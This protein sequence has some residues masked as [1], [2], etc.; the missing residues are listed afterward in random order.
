MAHGTDSVIDGRLVDS[1]I[2]SLFPRLGG[3]LSPLLV[4]LPSEQLIEEEAILLGELLDP[5]EDV[6]NGGVAHELSEDLRL[7]LPQGLLPPEAFDEAGKR[8][9]IV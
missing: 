7:L 4:F 1:P 3:F 9:R 8:A 5:I 6:V 2:A